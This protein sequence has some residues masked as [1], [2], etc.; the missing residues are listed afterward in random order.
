MSNVQNQIVNVDVKL[1]FAI[2]Q[3]NYYFLNSC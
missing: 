3:T 1:P 2:L